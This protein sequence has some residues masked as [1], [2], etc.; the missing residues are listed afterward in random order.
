MSNK[1]KYLVLEK[2]SQIVVFTNRF[3][4]YRQFN[5]LDFLIDLFKNNKFMFV[6]YN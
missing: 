1:L 3:L 5:L 6:F 2:L 4:G